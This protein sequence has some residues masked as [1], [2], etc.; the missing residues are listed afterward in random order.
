MKFPYKTRIHE[1]QTVWD[2][3]GPLP[4]MALNLSG[5]Q[6]TYLN[7]TEFSELHGHHGLKP[8]DV[9][10]FDSK[11]SVSVLWIMKEGI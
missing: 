8:L 7:G 11:C 2:T 10:Y 6:Y 3:P 5:E 9:L 4:Q 1:N